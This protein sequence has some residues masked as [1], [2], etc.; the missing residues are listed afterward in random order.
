MDQKSKTI[1]ISDKEF[2]QRYTINIRRMFLTACSLKMEIKHQLRG[3]CQ[4]NIYICIYVYNFLLL[5]YWRA[6]AEKPIEKL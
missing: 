2:F 3:I 1:P 6:L 4:L 5:G